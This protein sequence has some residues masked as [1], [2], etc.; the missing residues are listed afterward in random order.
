MSH[1]TSTLIAELKDSLTQQR[2][3][4]VAIHNYCRNADYFLRH[5]SER[6]IALETVTPDD[7]SRYL[8]LAVRRFRKRHGHPPAPRR[9]SI[10]RAGIHALLRHTLKCWPPEPDV[11][12]AG[13]SL[14]E[15]AAGGTRAGGNLH[16]STLGPNINVVF[17]L[18]GMKAAE[19]GPGCVDAAYGW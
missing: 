2:Y 18:G 15:M 3:N 9:E 8:R 19:M 10:P 12:D 17:A 6:G 1:K 4:R 5:L 16:L 13:E 11:A 7:V 14:P